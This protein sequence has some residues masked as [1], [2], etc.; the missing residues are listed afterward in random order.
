MGDYYVL[1]SFNNED[2]N[3]VGRHPMQ[4]DTNSEERYAIFIR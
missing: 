4:Q 1:T 3:R 2:I